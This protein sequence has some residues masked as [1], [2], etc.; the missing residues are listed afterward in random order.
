MS[1]SDNGCSQTNETSWDACEGAGLQFQIDTATIASIYV[2]AF[3]KNENKWKRCRFTTKESRFIVGKYP[4][5]PEKKHKLECTQKDE[6]SRY[7][8]VYLD[9]LVIDINLGQVTWLIPTYGATRLPPMKKLKLI[10]YPWKYSE[11]NAAEI[12]DLWDFSMLRKLSL[13][14]VN[15]DSFFGTINHSLL[16]NLESLTITDFI[17]SYCDD[18][19]SKFREQFR[20]LLEQLRHLKSFKLSYDAYLSVVSPNTMKQWSDKLVVLELR[21]LEI[22][23]MMTPSQVQELLDPCAKLQRLS[24][25]IEMDM[26]DVSPHHFSYSSPLTELGHSPLPTQFDRGEEGAQGIRSLGSRQ[27]GTR[28]STAQ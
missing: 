5:P 6:A 2:D 7:P 22:C 27:S 20:T 24:V 26:E 19:K 16:L 28:G 4:I 12:Y 14:H 15:L 25:D 8:K 13:T 1:N 11:H 9:L 17:D 18:Q 23:Q 10:N 21:G 3:L